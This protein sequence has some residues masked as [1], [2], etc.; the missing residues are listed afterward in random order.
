MSVFVLLGCPETVV[1]RTCSLMY[2]Q[3]ISLLVFG[4]SGSCGMVVAEEGEG[5]RTLFLVVLQTP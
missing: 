4:E 1:V 5:G 2:T 3:D